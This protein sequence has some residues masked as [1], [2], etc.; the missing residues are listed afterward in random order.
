MYP[1]PCLETICIENGKIRNL[2]WHQVRM[3][4][5]R[6]MLFQSEEPIE[7]SEI[8]HPESYLEKTKCRVVYADKVQSIDYQSY[9]IRPVTSLRLIEACGLSY[10]YKST[11]RSSLNKLFDQRGDAD[12]ILIIRNGLLTDT[13]IANIALWNGKNWHTP[14]TPL[15]EGTQRASLLERGILQPKDISVN[16]LS[17][18]RDLALF[19]AM[20]PL[21]D[22]I[23]HVENIR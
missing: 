5:T 13:S 6:R 22:L 17:H 20:I 1:F 7:L 2:P 8:I 14:K 3:K 23:V 11:D 21:G 19:N 18:Y 12:D 15:L 16:D 4:A 9:Q 10:F